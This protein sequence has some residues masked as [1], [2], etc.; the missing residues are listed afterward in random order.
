MRAEPVAS[1]HIRQFGK[2]NEPK[3]PTPIIVEILSKNHPSYRKAIDPYHHIKSI[4][5]GYNLIP[6][7]IVS[8]EKLESDELEAVESDEGELYN[9]ALAAILDAI[10]PF[11][12]DYPLS[13]IDDGKLCNDNTVYAGFYVIRRN[14]GTAKQSFSE[15]VLV[16]IYKNE[17]NVLLP[18]IDLQFRSMADA[19]CELAGQRTSKVDLNRVINN[20]LSTLIQTYS[21]ATDVYLFVHGQNARSY[22]NWLQDSKFDPKKTPSNKIHII[23]IRDGMNFEVPQAYGLSTEQETFGEG[24][25]SF[26]QGIFIP[27]DCDLEQ[28][29]FSQ[30]VLSVAKKSDMNRVSKHMSRFQSRTP[31]WKEP[32]PRA[33][34]ILATPSPEQFK[35][36][37][38]ITHDLRAR[39]WW[40]S[41]ECEYPVPLSLAAKLKE[42][43]FNDSELEYPD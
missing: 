13:L 9:R 14:K 38:A 32:Q 26:G 20:M 3:V 27:A 37:H 17:V 40:T 43:C 19:I 35:L 24:D 21:S 4:L 33:H 30:T 25:A 16:A 6:Q 36:H 10:L 7:C 2:I 15:P 31:A 34:N 42:W 8:S 41:D 22:W 5:P 29:L 23:R 39:H 1:A 28:V 11:N 18:A 12:Q